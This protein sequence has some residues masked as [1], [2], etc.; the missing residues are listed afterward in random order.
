MPIL[1]EI[2][3]FEGTFRTLSHTFVSNYVEFAIIK[4]SDFNVFRSGM[5]EIPNNH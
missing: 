1:S 3:G 5:S 2:Y 4:G